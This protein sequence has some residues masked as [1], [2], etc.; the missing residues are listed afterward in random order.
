MQ[1]Q[2]MRE[3][4]LC[5]LH[6]YCSPHFIIS[7]N[8]SSSGDLSVLSNYTTRNRN[9][10]F[11]FFFAL[12]FWFSFS[13]FENSR[14]FLRFFSGKKQENSYFQWGGIG[15]SFNF[16]RNSGFLSNFPLHFGSFSS[17]RIAKGYDI[18]VLTVCMLPSSHYRYA[19][20]DPFHIWS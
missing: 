19:D 3:T 7:T 18:F 2:S 9:S 17:K 10:S 14:N 11:Q 12:D 8:T 20:I 5:V 13:F 6:S 1:I 15:F 4:H 16:P